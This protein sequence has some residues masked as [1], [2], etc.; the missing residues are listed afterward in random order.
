M[1]SRSICARRTGYG[2]VRGAWLACLALG[3]FVASSAS[4]ALAQAQGVTPMEAI[5]ATGLARP[6]QGLSHARAVWVFRRPTAG[7]STTLIQSTTSASS[8]GRFGSL[9]HD[10]IEGKPSS[11]SPTAKYFVYGDGRTLWCAY[12]EGARYTETNLPK[13]LDPL[14]PGPQLARAP[15]ARVE[16]WL[17]EME[18]RGVVPTP[19]GAGLRYEARDVGRSGTFV[20]ELGAEGELAAMEFGLGDSS[21]RWEY[22]DFHS[23]QGRPIP[24]R[25]RGYT[26]SLKDG[27]P[28]ISNESAAT[29]AGFDCDTPAVLESITFN[30]VALDTRFFNEA[31]GEVFAPDKS[32]H[33]FT[34]NMKDG[35][36]GGSVWWSRGWLIGVIVAAGAS[37]I[38]AWKRWRR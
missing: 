36:W 2:F 14:N 32:Q 31:T 6:Y 17:T 28:D 8:D 25:L 11:S 12:G 37:A 16:A 4:L 3:A 29:L 18:R 38:V 22:S 15:W 33:L 21:L 35:S 7:G 24:R 19:L 1:S 34:I 9:E 20:L 30:P 5:V 27:V 10:S 13:E 23:V 26:F